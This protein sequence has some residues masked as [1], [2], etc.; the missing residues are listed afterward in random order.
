MRRACLVLPGFLAALLAGCFHGPPARPASWLRPFGGPTGP[1]VIVM[2]VALLEM[3]LGDPYVD[4]E[5]WGEVDG[6]VV[7]SDVR[8][9]V[10]D[11]GFRVGQVAG[12]QPP[13]LQQLVASDRYCV[14]RRRRQFR[15]G[16]PQQIALGGPVASLAVPFYREGRPAELHF[17]QAQCGLELTAKLVDGSVRLHCEPQVQHG[18]RKLLPQITAAGTSWPQDRSTERFPTVAWDL[19]LT[20]NEYLIVG[21]R[22]G[23]APTLGGQF[24]LAADGP[25]PVQRLLV[26][27]TSRANTPQA[28]PGEA[29]PVPPLAYQAATSTARGQRE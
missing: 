14:Q 13:R 29:P 5:V 9:A 17:E 3:P 1:D 24:F 22:S 23:K 6:T 2:D 11:N 12:T 21:T 7:D 25:K 4:R 15:A 28:L 18:E 8:A 27:R 26:L 10:E 19:T 20:A 16:E